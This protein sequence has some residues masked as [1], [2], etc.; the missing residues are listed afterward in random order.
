MKLWE[1]IGR[2]ELLDA[3]PWL[4]VWA[5]DVRLPDGR[6][7]QNFYKV[8]MPNYVMVLALDKTGNAVAL[9]QYRHPV[10]QIC[11][12]VPAGNIDEGEGPLD[13][14]K[15]ELLEEAGYAAEDWTFLGSFTKDANRGAGIGHFF[16]AQNAYR[17]AEA[18]AGEIEETFVDLMPFETLVQAL[19][20]GEIVLTSVAAA[21]SLAFT[22]LN[23]QTKSTTASS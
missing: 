13:A 14:A 23:T 16:L 22:Y 7:I 19:L 2:R 10:H 1:T 9:R 20:D 3:R 5:E 17:V 18:D 15:R 21:V 11:L 8:D 4:H 6:V 12:G